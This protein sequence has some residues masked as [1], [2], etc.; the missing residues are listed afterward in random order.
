M[1][2]DIVYGL[3]AGAVNL[4]YSPLCEIQGMLIEKRLCTFQGHPE[5]DKKIMTSILN[6][7]R[8]ANIFDEHIY[9]DAIQRA[10]NSHQGGLVLAAVLRFLGVL[11]HSLDDSKLIQ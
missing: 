5:F 6:K 2:R 1:H 11:D 3:P 4:G 10:D 7:R 8:A 9:T